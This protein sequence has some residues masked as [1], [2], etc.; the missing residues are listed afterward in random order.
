MDDLAIDQSV[1]SATL[2]GE[3]SRFLLPGGAVDFVVGAEL[4]RETSTAERDAWQLGVIPA[5]APFPAGTLLG[6]VSENDSLTFRPQIGIKNQHG[7]YDARDVFAEVSLPLLADAAFARELGL[8]LAGRWSDYSTVGSTGSW[9]A[10]VLWAPI[11]DLAFRG[12]VSRS[13]R[14]PNITELFRPEIG[15]NFRPADPCDAAQIHALLAEDA[16]LG[17][18]FLNNCTIRLRSIGLEPLDADGRHGFADPLS[19]S[20]D[21][22]TSGNPDLSEETA[23]TTT[24]GLV[25]QPSLLAGFGVA[26]DFWEIDI[27]DAIESVTSQNIVDGCYRGASLNPDF[28]GLF[29]RND[30]PASAQFGGFDFLRTVDINFARLKT[31][32]IDFSAG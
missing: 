11:R 19:A 22:I 5:G 17:R 24:Y 6:D 1:A 20:F 26:V 9:K 14:A 21:G 13:V 3:T 2:A 28:C 15:V 23:R 30:D 10:N 8:D 7:E 16:V 25:L 32:G 29:T 4:R 12:G 27:D 31:S 18:N